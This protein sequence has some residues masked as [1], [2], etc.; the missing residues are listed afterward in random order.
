MGDDEE[1]VENV[2]GQRRHSEE[3]HRGDSLP[4][5]AQKGG[6]SVCSPGTPRRLP[7]PAHDGSFRNI[8]IEHRKF[9]EDA[10]NAPSR[11]LCSHAEDEFTQFYTHKFSS[12][13]SSMP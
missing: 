7:H 8:E 9:D 13:R 5:I 1:T 3:V 4:M 6:P 12:G 11:V 10:R 2:K